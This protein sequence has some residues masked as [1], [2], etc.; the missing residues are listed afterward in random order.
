MLDLPPCV[1]DIAEHYQVPV[2]LIAGVRAQEGGTVGV[3]N[4]PR[5]NGSYDIGPMQINTWWWEDHKGQLQQFGITKESVQYNFCQNISV[6]TYILKEE[7]DRYN[8]I[9]KALS[10]YN[11]G[12]PKYNGYSTKVLNRVKKLDPFFNYT[13]RRSTNDDT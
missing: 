5:F 1:Y 13:P 3:M 8:D 6:G 10:A 9:H 4:G 11:S 2:V 7:L 12:K